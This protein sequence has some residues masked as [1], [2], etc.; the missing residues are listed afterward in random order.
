LPPD[1]AL[2]LIFNSQNF[3][4]LKAI[5]SE[6]R[7][8]K[9]LFE[10]SLIDQL[11]WG[12]LPETFEEN[13]NRLKYLGDYL[14]TYLEKDVRSIETITDLRLYQE[15]IKICA[16]LTGFV[17]ND[18]KI[19]DAL[20][21]SRNTLSKY[22]DYLQATLQYVE[23]YP[24]IGSTTQRLVKSPKGY[25]INNGLV[26]YLTGIHDVGILKTTGLI[27]HRFENWFLNEV[28]S[29][30]DTSSEH[31]QISFWRTG[32]DA[33]VDFIV[34]HGQQVIPFEVTFA[35]QVPAKKLNNL[36]GLMRSYPKAALGVF[37]YM[38]PL[39]FDEENRLLYLPAWMI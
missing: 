17:R 2:D 15:L 22:R 28:Q 33:E 30:L 4:Q 12:G 34:A 16:E 18:K 14:Q 6:L 38:G 8:F 37:C 31:H 27:G 10:E 39:S 11:L 21:C 20:H 9:R 32:A 19:I 13:S 23:I 36:K 25:L 26:S 5:C 35:S 1:T 29:W 3:K 7:P 24:F